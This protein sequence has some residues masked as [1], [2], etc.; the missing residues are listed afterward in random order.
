[1]SES[2]EFEMYIHSLKSREQDAASNSTLYA[3]QNIRSADCVFLAED[4]VI[5]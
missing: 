4:E 1:M 3:V 5:Y 2:P